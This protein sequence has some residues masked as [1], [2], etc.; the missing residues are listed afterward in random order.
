MRASLSSVLGVA[1]AVFLGAAA[2]ARAQVPAPA[3]QDEI[4]TAPVIVDASPSF[5]CEASRP[6]PRTCARRSSATG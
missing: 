2:G 3:P 4:A 1:F 5:A 6:F